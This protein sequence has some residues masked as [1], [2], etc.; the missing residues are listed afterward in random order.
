MNIS[1]TL[2]QRALNLAL[3][4]R[5]VQVPKDAP[6]DELEFIADLLEASAQFEQTL[7]TAWETHGK[8]VSDRPDSGHILDLEYLASRPKSLRVKRQKVKVP[9][10]DKPSK[11]REPVLPWGTYGCW[12]YPNKLWP[13]PP[14][15]QDIPEII[16]QK[17]LRAPEKEH[18]FWEHQNMLVWFEVKG[19]LPKPEVT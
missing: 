10:D 15:V 11:P 7:R 12:D 17:R 16:R 3:S 13:A 9:K 18:K 8:N 14:T 6:P 19:W 5:R 1:R 2:Y 4:F